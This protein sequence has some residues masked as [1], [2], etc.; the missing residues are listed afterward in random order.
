[1]VM[2]F[3]RADYGYISD[4]GMFFIPKVM[5]E[6]SEIKACKNNLIT[7]VKNE[8]QDGHICLSYYKT[9]TMEEYIKMQKSMTKDIQLVDEFGRVILLR[10]H[11][12]KL[13]IQPNDILVSYLLHDGTIKIRKLV[14]AQSV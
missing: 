4:L 2:D 6:E 12:A 1:M 9:V 11:R 3:V 13:K 5:Q 7:L 14:K 10:K 8:V